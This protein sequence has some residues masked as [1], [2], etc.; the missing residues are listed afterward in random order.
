MNDGLR[1]TLSI[2]SVSRRPKALSWTNHGWLLSV[3]GEVGENGTRRGRGEVGVRLGGSG[4]A[5]D[6]L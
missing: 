5:S 3:K 4:E 1:Q 2:V 6:S